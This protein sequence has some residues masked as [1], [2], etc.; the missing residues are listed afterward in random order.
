MRKMVTILVEDILGQG[1][2]IL[3]NF[4]YRSTTMDCSVPSKLLYGNNGIIYIL[5][6]F[7][8]LKFLSGFSKINYE[9]E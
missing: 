5:L 9:L 7:I 8:G 2:Q 1:K 6:C 4:S 3:R